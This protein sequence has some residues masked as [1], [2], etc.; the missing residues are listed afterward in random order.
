MSITNP[1]NFG[2]SVGSIGNSSNRP[3]VSGR[4]IVIRKWRWKYKY[5]IGESNPLDPGVREYY[6]EYVDVGEP[7]EPWEPIGGGGSTLGG[8]GGGVNPFPGGIR[9]IF[10]SCV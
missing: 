7:D 3:E 8:G 9:V 6:D 4:I 5:G 10:K 2:P 1:F